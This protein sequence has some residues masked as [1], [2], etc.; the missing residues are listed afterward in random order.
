MD[1]KKTLTRSRPLRKSIKTSVSTRT[2]LTWPDSFYWTSAASARNGPP[3]FSVRGDPARPGPKTCL[4]YLL[5]PQPL[6]FLSQGVDD[7][8]ALLTSGN[9]F[10]QLIEQILGKEKICLFSTAGHGR[11][12][13]LTVLFQ[14]N[15]IGCSLYSQIC[16]RMMSPASSGRSPGVAAQQR[17]EYPQ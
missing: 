14:D 16:T 6:Q 13:H 15:C 10:P 4:Q 1:A 2:L 17:F 8:S 3:L 12:R 9:T 11:P 5:K 7:E